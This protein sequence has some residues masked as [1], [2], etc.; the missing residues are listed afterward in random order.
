MLGMAMTIW[1]GLISIL[2]VIEANIV[3]TEANTGAMSIA[4]VG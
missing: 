1:T 3:I 4:T 2:P